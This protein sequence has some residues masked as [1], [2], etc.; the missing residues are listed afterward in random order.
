M[1]MCARSISFVHVFTIIL[2]DVRTV[3]TV[4][5]FGFFIYIAING[6]YILGIKMI[7]MFNLYLPDLA[8]G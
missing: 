8:S 6:T 5:Y 4:W 3:L 7:D 1:Y 2:L